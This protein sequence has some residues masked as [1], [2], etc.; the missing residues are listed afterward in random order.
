MVEWG[1]D[2]WEVHTG[3]TYESSVNC[4]FFVLLVQS[5]LKA[6]NH[7]SFSS[8]LDFRGTRHSHLK[9]PNNLSFFW[10]L[11]FHEFRL[12]HPK[13]LNN[14][15][16]FLLLDIASFARAISRYRIILVSP[17]FSALASLVQLGLIPT[18][19]PR[20]VLRMANASSDVT[21]RNSSAGLCSLLISTGVKNLPWFF[22]ISWTPTQSTWS[23]LPPTHCV[24][25]R[26]LSIMPCTKLTRHFS[27]G[28]S[29]QLTLENW[30]TACY[31]TDATYVTC[32]S[33][34]FR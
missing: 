27:R 7:L 28:S 1:R 11:V 17:R 26:L 12:G 18:S 9:T 4:F 33:D 5:H 22:I 21:S 29:V 16:F 2:F 19:K 10:F 13:T 6:L 3:A 30:C 25:T 8:F 14:F 15:S 24:W 20:T 34:L 23:H 32:Q 31:A